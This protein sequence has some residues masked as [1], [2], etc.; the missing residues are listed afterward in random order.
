[1]FFAFMTMLF[2]AI[3][4]MG[5]CEGLLLLGFALI[6]FLWSAKFWDLD[7]NTVRYCL[8]C[9]SVGQ[10]TTQ[11][12][13]RCQ[14]SCNFH[15][16]SCQNPVQSYP[17]SYGGHRHSY[18]YDRNPSFAYSTSTAPGAGRSRGHGH[19]SRHHCLR[20]GK[21]RKLSTKKAHYQDYS[22]G[23]KNHRNHNDVGYS[24]DDNASDVSNGSSA[25]N[26][27][28]VDASNPC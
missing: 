18:D 14:P 3:A 17:V 16:Q 10:M 22:R 4:K 15:C 1:M 13:A 7:A 12:C 27:G 26:Q 11:Y 19:K 5:V 8:R 2:Y 25:T 23:G 6:I 21:L 28:A 9:L 24:Y 20:T